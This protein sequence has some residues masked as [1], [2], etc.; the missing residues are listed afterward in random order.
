[1]AH[2]LWWDLSSRRVNLLLAAILGVFL[3][4]LVFTPWGWAQEKK[5][6]KTIDEMSPE[7]KQSLDLR[8]SYEIPRDEQIPYL[9]AKYKEHY[10]PAGP[11]IAEKL[12]PLSGEDIAYLGDVMGPTPRWDHDLVL[13][14]AAI[15]TRGSLYQNR[16]VASFQFPEY[17]YD[18]YTDKLYK[19]K[20][21]GILDILRAA[22][23]NPPENY[24]FGFVQMDYKIV[25][26]AKFNHG[27][28]TKTSDRWLYVPSLRK[29]RRIPSPRRED[30]VPQWDFTFDDNLGRPPWE[31]EH[32]IIG[33]DIL[34]SKDFIRFPN[35]V[36]KM[37]MRNKENYL[38]LT[39]VD[40]SNNLPI[41]WSLEKGA[42][43]YPYYTPDGGVECYVVESKPK[44]DWLP[45]YY[46]GRL[47][48]WYE[49][50]LGLPLRF[51][52]YGP[53][54]DKLFF[55]ME[56]RYWHYFPEQGRRGWALQ[57]FLAWDMRIDHMTRSWRTY[58]HQ[59]QPGERDWQQLFN[60]QRMLRQEFWYDVSTGQEMYES[61]D[62]Y[63]LRPK[64]YEGKFPE[65]RKIVLSDELREAIKKQEE[66]GRLVWY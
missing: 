21:G 34:Y 36:K 2:F 24:G 44:G 3:S 60:P 63:F 52:E 20:A 46:V 41:L 18:T 1:M 61:A 35:T 25:P 15:N 66:S 32:R 33:T 49:K 29:I 50:H 19:M 12:V 42:D 6:W 54:D 45:G 10:P 48:T 39:G 31:Y 7:E 51:E 47:I 40:V 14:G 57:S 30:V 22:Y 16:L 4:N 11:L 26:D 43:A 17:N 23:D 53:K 27:V 59:V 55:I 9:P 28:G 62:H 8:W 56:Q 37:A 58:Y 65:Y 38:K 13:G 5:T 64:L